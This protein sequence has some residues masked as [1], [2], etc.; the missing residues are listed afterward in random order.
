MR[1]VDERLDVPATVAE[2]DGDHQH[3]EQ[4]QRV[5]DHE[6]QTFAHADGIRDRDA[7]RTDGAR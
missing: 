4:P 3:R 6:H 1:A 5:D 7:G 2:V